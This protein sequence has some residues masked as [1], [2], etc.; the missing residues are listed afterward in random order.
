VADGVE[1]AVER[2]SALHQLCGPEGEAGVLLFAAPTPGPAPSCDEG[3]AFR[4]VAGDIVACAER[5]VLARCPRGC[6]REGASVDVETSLPREK[7]FALL[8][9]R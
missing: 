3:E 2:G 8:C 1:L 4:C 9:L 5:R 7:A 6:F